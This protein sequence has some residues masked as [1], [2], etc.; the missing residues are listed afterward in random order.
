MDPMVVLLGV[1]VILIIINYMYSKPLEKTSKKIINLA[2]SKM[3]TPVK[4][5]IQDAPTE[6][7]HY[8]H[9][10]SDENNK[11]AKSEMAQDLKHHMDKKILYQIKYDYYN[12]KVK[13]CLNKKVLKSASELSSNKFNLNLDNVPPTLDHD[14]LTYTLFGTANNVFYNQHYVLYENEI[15]DETN[16]FNLYKY[17]L[18]N[19]KN[20]NIDIKLAVGPRQKISINDVVYLSSGQFQVGPLVINNI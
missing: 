10:A 20:T 9:D 12:K 15:N 1:I 7:K 11:L 8:M 16:N 13:Q 14:D 3:D 6:V 19:I 2:E 18:V 17:L 5:N 4:H